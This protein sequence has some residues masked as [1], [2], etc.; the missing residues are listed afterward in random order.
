MGRQSNQTINV[1][2]S[3]IS[4]IEN[5]LNDKIYNLSEPMLYIPLDSLDIVELL[6]ELERKFNISFTDDECNELSHWSINKLIEN[7]EKKIND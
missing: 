6:L 2:Q 7:I 1:R 4:I 5:I 3:V